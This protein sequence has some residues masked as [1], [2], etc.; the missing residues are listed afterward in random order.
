MTEEGLLS[1]TSIKARYWHQSIYS[2]SI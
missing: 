2:K 1:Y